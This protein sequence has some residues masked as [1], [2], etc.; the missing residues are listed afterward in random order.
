MESAQDKKK[1]KEDWRKHERMWQL[2]KKEMLLNI[3]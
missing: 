2:K 1:G 3:T